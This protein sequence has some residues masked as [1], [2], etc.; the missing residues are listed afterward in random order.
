[1]EEKAKIMAIFSERY[2]HAISDHKSS[3]VSIWNIGLILFSILV[4]I[5]AFTYGIHPF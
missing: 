1:M 2:D 3:N 5:T 4:M